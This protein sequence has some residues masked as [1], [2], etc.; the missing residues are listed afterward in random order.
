MTDIVV[1]AKVP[2][3]AYEY[4]GTL[5]YDTHYFWQVKAIEPMPSD[6]SATFCFRTENAP[7]SQ[8]ST[9]PPGP[10]PGWIWIIIVGGV[11]LDIGLLVLILRRLM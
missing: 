8:P 4:E 9:S 1:E 2:T 11:I 5:E 3:N 6:C 10:V 7:T